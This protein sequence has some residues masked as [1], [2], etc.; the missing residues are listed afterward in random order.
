VYGPVR[1]VVWQGSEGD[2]RP[3]ADHTR[4]H[5]IA[6]GTRAARINQ[7]QRT[8]RSAG[9]ERLYHYE[10]F[11]PEYL[12]DILI[13]GRVYCS[14][15]A[16][17]NDPWD[18]RPWFDSEALD[19]PNVVE[20][21]IQWIFSF[22]PPGVVS[23]ERVRATDEAIRTNPSYRR[24]VLD[25]WSTDFIKMI[26]DRWRIYCLTPV[27]DSTLMWSHYAH[28]HKEI[29]LEFGLQHQLFGS[30]LEVAYLSSY[31]KWSPH[32]LQESASF[33]ILLTKSDDWYYER[34]FRIIGLSE[35]VNRP[36]GPLEGHPLMVKDGFLSV[37]PGS[38]K[39][40]IAG[41]E[42]DHATIKEVVMA[43]NPTLKLKRAV[44]SPTKYRLEIAE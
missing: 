12:R 26:P 1:T 34:E 29:C 15:P 7:M 3:Y 32:S 37:P 39:A 33:G 31:P 24:Q 41:C 2:R 21:L 44:R 5:G 27:P 4:G 42:A 13:N 43:A 23:D 11:N 10:R 30:A 40:I 6:P 35:G 20:D 19:E 28:N 18:C 38:L 36:F 17:L 8:A 22:D 14:D 16:N 9:L 25:R